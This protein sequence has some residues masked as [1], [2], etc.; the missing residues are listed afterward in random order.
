MTPD[1]VVLAAIVAVVVILVAVGIVRAAGRRRGANEDAF[2]AGGVPYVA[3]GTRGEAKTDLSPDGVVLAA[4]E[5]WT[6]RSRNGAPIAAGQDIRVV[7]QDWL[8]LIVD[9]EPAGHRAG[10]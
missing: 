10:E 1:Q 8:T 3:A 2:G 5:Q 6:A 7:G 4:G 9:P